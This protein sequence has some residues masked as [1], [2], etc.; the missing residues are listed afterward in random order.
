MKSIQS[1]QT[2]K[3]IVESSLSGVEIVSKRIGDA[4]NDGFDDVLISVK[5]AYN[6]KGLVN[7]FTNC[8]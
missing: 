2:F 1:P 3:I 4:D 5:Y 6:E 7:V 8:E